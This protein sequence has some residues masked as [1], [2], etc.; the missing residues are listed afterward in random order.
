MPNSQENYPPLARERGW[1]G[2]TDLHVKIFADGRTPQVVVAKPSKYNMLDKRAIEM[3]LK[4]WQQAQLPD[5]LRGKDFEFDITVIFT[6][7]KS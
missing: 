3:L 1:E 2:E 7:V 4:G 5:N 6:L